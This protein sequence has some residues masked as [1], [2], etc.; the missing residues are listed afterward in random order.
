[1]HAIIEHL[2]VL[3]ARLGVTVTAQTL[4]AQTLHDQKGHIIWRSLQDTL[5]L[6]GLRGKLS[7]RAL[8]DI[9]SEALPVLLTLRDSRACVLTAIAQRSGGYEYS[10]E[11]ANGSQEQLSIEALAAQYAGVCWFVKRLPTAERRSELPE[12]RMNRSWL[13]QVLW[14]Y[15]S[16]YF[17]AIV[18]T[19]VVNVMS[20]VG[21]LY[22]MQVYDR[23]VPNRAYETLW[24][25]TIG[26]VLA[27]AFECIGR[28][29][30]SEL[31]DAAGKKADLV[32]SAALFRRVMAIDLSRK[33]ISSGSYASNLRDFESVR[34][35]LSSGMFLALV[36]LPFVLL[37]VAVIFLFAGPLGWVTLTVMALI[38]LMGFAV[39]W[40][41][42]KA[43]SDSMRAS[44]MRQGLAVEAI[45]GL[46]TLKSHNAAAWAQQQWEQANAETA[47][48]SMKTKRLTNTVM[49][50]TQMLVQL[51]S[52]AVVF[53][54]VYLIHHENQSER[55]TMGA[56]IAAVI[57]TGR[58]IAPLSQ[59]AALMTRLHQTSVALKGIDAIVRQPSERD[60]KR[61]YVELPLPKGVLH[62][63]DL[64]YRYTKDGAM[65]LENVNLF[66]DAGEKVAI[67]GRIGSGKSTLLRTLAGLYPAQQ[68]QVLIDGLNIGQIEP[69]ELRQHVTLLGQS[70]RLFLGTLRSNLALAQTDQDEDKQSFE[71]ALKRFGLDAMVSAHPMGLDMHLGEDG[72]GLSGGQKQLLGLARFSLRNPRVVLL[73]E[74]TS[75]LDQGSERTAL[76]A[77]M[78]WGS[79]RTVVIVTHR[80]QVLE[81][82]TRVIVMD[83]GRVV[84]DGPKAKVLEALAK[85]L[86]L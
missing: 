8:Q 45:E 82:V 60:D 33:P 79:D 2:S 17:Q 59:V 7:K 31:T 1:M 63:T 56:L 75:G 35:F 69:V 5:P 49:S 4:A 70:P 36:D 53:W 74:P 30:R 43:T 37:Y 50:L 19:L 64:N 27:I 24:A 10:I 51:S 34:E 32:I 77:L 14:R 65:A 55:I 61:T 38:V 18:A 28:L 15:K 29:V 46:E 23:V 58:A 6:Y 25:L 16:F 9:P 54:G 26:A 78:Q 76:E 57:L 21:S 67:L 47:K 80:P 62:T 11:W 41:L 85:G 3:A 13:W 52:V 84:M 86:K 48:S 81:F 72:A 66:I 44:S 73:D 42:A 12:Y 22:V 71:L 20:L 39:Q 40:P 83:K 68:G